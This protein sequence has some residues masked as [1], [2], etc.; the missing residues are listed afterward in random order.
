M[1]S[2]KARSSKLLVEEQAI[3][4]FLNRLEPEFQHIFV[5]SYILLDLLHLRGIQQHMNHILDTLHH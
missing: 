2:M 5:D 4:L 3:I 1:D